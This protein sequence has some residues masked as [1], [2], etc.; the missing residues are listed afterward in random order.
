MDAVTRTFKQL[1]HSTN[2]FK[3]RPFG[4]HRVLFVFN[5]LPDVERIINSET[6]SFDKH[7]VVLQQYE[8]DSLPR[9]LKFD[10]ATFWAQVHDMPVRFMLRK[11]AENI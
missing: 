6:W 7:L 5:N 1:W 10:K 8:N 11:V 9:N 2:G 3:I 4:D